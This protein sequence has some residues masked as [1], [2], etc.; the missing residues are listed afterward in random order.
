VVLPH[1]DDE[2][3]LE[4]TRYFPSTINV[5]SPRMISDVLVAPQVIMAGHEPGIPFEGTAYVYQCHPVAFTDID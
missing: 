1:T 2:I 4:D 5:L 3:V